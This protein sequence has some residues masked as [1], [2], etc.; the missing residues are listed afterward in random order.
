[1]TNRKIDQKTTK[2]I[3]IDKGLHSLLK[4]RTAEDGKTIKEVVEGLLSEYLE[5]KNNAEN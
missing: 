5:V 2:Q 1:M 4:V 3:V